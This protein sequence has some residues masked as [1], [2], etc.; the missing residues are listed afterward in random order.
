MSP[1][2]R[3]RTKFLKTVRRRYLM[4]KLTMMHFQILTDP[5]CFVHTKFEDGHVITRE[6]AYGI[7]V[8]RPGTTYEKGITLGID[9]S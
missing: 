4:R 2:K 5:H 6:Y 8:W 9:R 7:P 1:Y 3:R